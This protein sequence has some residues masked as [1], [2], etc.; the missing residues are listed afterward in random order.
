LE[1]GECFHQG[2]LSGSSLP[3][4]NAPCGMFF[5]HF[6][7][8]PGS[9]CVAFAGAAEESHRDLVIV[10]AEGSGTCFCEPLNG[11]AA[12]AF[13]HFLGRSL[14][15]GHFG[16][17]SLIQQ[18]FAFFEV[19]NFGALWQILSRPSDLTRLSSQGEFA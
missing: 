19:V 14:F 15:E 10:V 12:T 18:M 3:L 4:V 13:S 1:L 9:R 2:F 17:F 11:V 7:E 8:Q 16:P 6:E 5:E